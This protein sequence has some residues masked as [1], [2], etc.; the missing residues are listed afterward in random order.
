VPV[1]LAVALLACALLVVGGGL[2]PRLFVEPAL[3]A[4]RALTGF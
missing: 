1:A 4:G 3:R 2:A